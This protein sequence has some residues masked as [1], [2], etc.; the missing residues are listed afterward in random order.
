MLPKPPSA[1]PMESNSKFVG[2]NLTEINADTALSG[3]AQD[4]AQTSVSRDQFQAGNKVGFR[5]G[6]DQAQQGAI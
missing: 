4:Y 1:K 5:A 6:L 3:F 2:Q